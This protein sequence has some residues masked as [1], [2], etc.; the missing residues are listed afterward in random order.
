MKN[1]LFI[2]KKEKEAVNLF[3]IFSNLF[4]ERPV[5][6][7]DI[8]LLSIFFLENIGKNNP[9]SKNCIYVFKN[10]NINTYE[11]N[12]K[13]LKNYMD[14]GNSFIFIITPNEYKEL[15]SSE[16][17]TVFKSISDRCLIFN[18]DYEQ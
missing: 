8:N 2:T 16:I 18:Y 14:C 10:I 12:L 9:F 15:I 6:S 5:Y 3:L 4:I 11:K 7:I 1:F 17:N 13:D